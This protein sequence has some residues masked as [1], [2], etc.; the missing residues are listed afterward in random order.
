MSLRVLVVDDEPP[1]R[2][3]FTDL[4]E[5]R[6]HHAV[7]FGEF[8]EIETHDRFDRVILDLSLPSG[9][10]W[11]WARAAEDLVGRPDRVIITTA[12]GDPSAAENARNAGYI[13]L[14]KPFRPDALIEALEKGR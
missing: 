11:D 5:A 13:F 3:L 6:G 1:M 2:E 9:S 12:S 7:A 4:L 8:P 14:M 10:G